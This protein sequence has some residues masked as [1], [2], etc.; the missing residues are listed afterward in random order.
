MAPDRK[1]IAVQPGLKQ[2]SYFV[3]LEVTS[4]AALKPPVL[5]HVCRSS[6]RVVAL[7][8]QADQADNAVIGILLLLDYAL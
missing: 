2:S 6:S 8:S 4:S 3:D 1:H 7:M 5:V